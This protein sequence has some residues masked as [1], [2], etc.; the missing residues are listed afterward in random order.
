[1]N[2]LTYFQPN[3]KNFDTKYRSKSQAQKRQISKRDELRG[4]SWK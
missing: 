4:N 1:M 3:C 2:L